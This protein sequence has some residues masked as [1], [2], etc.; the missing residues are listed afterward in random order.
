MEMPEAVANQ[1]NA[2]ISR[3]NDY[4]EGIRNAIASDDQ[5][6][7]EGRYEYEYREIHERS[8]ICTA[9]SAAAIYEMAIQQRCDLQDCHGYDFSIPPFIIEWS[10]RAWEW[11]YRTN[12]DSP[13]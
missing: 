11:E 3:I 13:E 8:V 10:Q 5:F 4:N 12:Q 1:L 7:G 2:Y 9:F 6:G